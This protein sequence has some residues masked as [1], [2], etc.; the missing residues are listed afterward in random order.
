MKKDNVV[1]GIDEVAKDFVSNIQTEKKPELSIPKRS[2]DNVIYDDNE[3]FLRLG[4]KRVTRALSTSTIKSL[5]QTILMMELS[6]SAIEGEEHLTKREAYYVSKNWNDAR[7]DTQPQSDSVIEDLEARFGVNREALGFT[8]EEKGGEVAGEL[9]VVDINRATNRKI[10]IDCTRFGSGAYSIPI[11]TEHLEFKTDADFILVIETAGMF[12]RLTNRAFWEEYNCIL[13]SMGGVPTRACRR[14][15]RRLSDETGLPVYVFT[16]GDPYGYG[17]IYR[18][19]TAGSANAAHINEHFCV[20]R[21]RFLG[22]TPEDIRNYELPTHPLK[23]QDIKRCNDILK[24][25]PFFQTHKEWE[26]AIN[27]MLE[28]GVR[29]EQ[30]AFA[31]YDLNYVADVYLPEKLNHPEL[32]LP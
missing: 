26:K 29:A 13:I 6:K 23:E 3:G 22:V 27:E 15:I 19:L 32:M 5:A 14:F 11:A 10:Q 25:D 18:T 31:V 12:Q 20:P 4:K 8:S 17:N 28:M 9:T 16:D 1:D 7:F 30:Q 2:L 21:A 24:N